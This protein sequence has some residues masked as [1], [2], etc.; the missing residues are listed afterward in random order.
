MKRIFGMMPSSEVE[1]EKR[2][3]DKYGLIITI[4][5]GPHGW[6]IL[7]AD[8]S[9]DY[10]DE[11]NSTDK[12]FENAYNLAESKIGEL[13]EITNNNNNNKLY[14]NKKSASCGCE[15]MYMDID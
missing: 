6:S 14:C 3:K 4:Q 2:Y 5:A 12:N 7:W 8:R 15:A 11:D 9:S 10:K 13:T 1:K